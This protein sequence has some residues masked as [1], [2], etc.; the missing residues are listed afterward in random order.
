M[1]EEIKMNNNS[2]LVWGECPD[3]SWT[4]IGHKRT[5]RVSKKSYDLWLL[6]IE[7]GNA[8][9]VPRTS[10][11]PTFLYQCA[12]FDHNSITSLLAERDEKIKSLETSVKALSE[13]YSKMEIYKDALKEISRMHLSKSLNS[14]KLLSQEALSLHKKGVA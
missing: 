5:Y 2:K 4:A 1:S 8:C 6:E 7:Y 3:K 10:V 14:A 13:V 12:Q 11:N 9:P